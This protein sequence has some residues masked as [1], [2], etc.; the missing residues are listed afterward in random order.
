MQKF[1]ISYSAHLEFRLKIREIPHQLPE[2]IFEISK[3]HYFDNQTRKYAA[4]SNA[5]YKGRVREIAVIYEQVN[6]EIILIT[7]HPLKDLQKL[8][9][10]KS[11]RW[12]RI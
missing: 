8:H 9:R 5:R 4:V 11:R 10:I 12:Q 1:K 7:I 6:N 2:Q 3:E